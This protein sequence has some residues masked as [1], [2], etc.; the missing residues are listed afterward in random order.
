MFSPDREPHPAVDE[1]KFLMQ[2]V[3]F[4]PMSGSDASSLQI[5]TT[6]PVVE[7][8]VANR[9]TFLDLSHLFWNFEVKSSVSPDAIYVGRF[10]VK[11]DWC[12][13][14][15]DKALPKIHELESKRPLSGIS[16]FLHV[17][18]R[19]KDKVTW[20]DRGHVL[21]SH[22]FCLEFV[23][24]STPVLATPSLSAPFVLTIS[25]DE[26]QLCVWRTE[27]TSREGTA[28]D[29]ML[30][31][32][33]DRSRGSLVHYSPFGKNLL[34][35]G[36]MPN[37]TR[38]TTDNDRGGMELALNFLFP[39]LEVQGIHSLL[40]GN[41]DFS[42]WSR[43]RRIGLTED[44]PPQT[45]GI[46]TEVTFVDATKVDIDVVS[47]VTSADGRHSLFT[48]SS[49]Y[50]VYRDGSI[51]L[52]IHTCPS[53]I[54]SNIPSLPRVGIRI[55]LD[56]SL[57]RVQYFGRGPGE[58]WYRALTFYLDIT[59]SN[60]PFSSPP[61]TVPELSGSQGG[62]RDGILRNDAIL[63]GLHV[64]SSLGERIEVRL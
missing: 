53:R 52:A 31:V 57:F 37:F 44:L 16:Y 29:R 1:I 33:I 11:G 22:Q 12:V 61:R 34:C 62:C 35:D 2:P 26:S 18:G 9:Y 63:Y 54:L 6:D 32:A 50:T 60:S 51:R 23:G 3:S 59:L 5:S 46:L 17:R 7:L 4:S 42:Y 20:A 21:V 41:Q 25:N 28:G 58:V 64:H 15:L 30:L 19:L 24:P 56:R 14:K 38:A 55:Q 39:G 48:F 47:K 49:H 8:R 40:H 27:S 43:W 36:V 45:R 10:E 13:L